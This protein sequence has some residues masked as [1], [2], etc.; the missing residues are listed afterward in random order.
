MPTGA[1][2]G[3]SSAE[4]QALS[5]EEKDGRVSYRKVQYMLVP[6]DSFPHM[7][8]PPSLVAG[9]MSF[10]GKILHHDFLD[11]RGAEMPIAW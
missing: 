8:A 6:H 7:I 3:A 4:H 9:P 1:R 11:N 10:R 2:G 5:H